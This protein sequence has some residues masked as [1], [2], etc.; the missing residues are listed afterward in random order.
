MADAH[1][2]TNAGIWRLLSWVRPVQAGR[3]AMGAAIRTGQ[4]LVLGLAEAPATRERAAKGATATRAARTMTPGQRGSRA[5]VQGRPRGG[6]Q[7][8]STC[9]SKTSPLCSRG[10]PGLP[11]GPSR[12]RS[13]GGRLRVEGLTMMHGSAAL[14]TGQII[15][16]VQKTGACVWC[17]ESWRGGGSGETMQLW[18][19]AVMPSCCYAGV[20]GW[21][22]CQAPQNAILAVMDGSAL[23]SFS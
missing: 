4:A 11:G 14:S 8:S 9:F 1:A 22:I 10:A 21:G 18:L 16:R 6:R 20:S 2:P 5:G 15:V 12:S 13:S 19:F 23:G 17:K 7:M 3:A